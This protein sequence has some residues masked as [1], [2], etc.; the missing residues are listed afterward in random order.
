MKKLFVIFTGLALL[1]TS[2]EPQDAMD[3]DHFTQEQIDVLQ[4]L[5]GTFQEVDE[6]EFQIIVLEK[7]NP[8][9]ESLVLDLVT[10]LTHGKIRIPM[11]EEESAYTA[12]LDC[13]FV[14]SEDGNTITLIT[15]GEVPFEFIFDIK[16]I[17]STS[18]RMR[19]N[20]DGDVGDWFTFTKI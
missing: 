1:L 5:N 10:I 6:A 17:S 7:Y 19:L 14:V 8:P 20:E 16:L 15:A 2:C 9:R 3:L 4:V 11:P 12:Y 13:Y 18:F